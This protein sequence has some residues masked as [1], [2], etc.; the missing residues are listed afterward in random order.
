MNVY[1]PCHENIE[2]WISLVNLEIICQ[3]PYFLFCYGGDFNI[4]RRVCEKSNKIYGCL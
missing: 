2:R 3:M 4:V 1:G